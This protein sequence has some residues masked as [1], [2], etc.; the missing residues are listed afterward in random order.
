MM[1]FINKRSILFSWF[2]SYALFL[3]IF[4]I[5]SFL[6][7]FNTSGI[8]ENEI[9]T[10][11]KMLLKD[12]QNELD[13]VLEEGRKLGMEIY[14]NPRIQSILSVKNEITNDDYIDANSSI[15]D[16]KATA[17]LYKSV[18]HFYIVLKNKN[19][20]V[21]YSGLL[22]MK[23][24]YEIYYPEYKDNYNSWLG[25]FDQKLLESYTLPFNSQTLLY[26]RTLSSTD[27]DNLNNSVIV[28]IDIQKL[29]DQLSVI[30][31]INNGTALI[32]DKNNSLIA[33]SRQFEMTEY[34]RTQFTKNKNDLF[35]TNISGEKVV[36]SYINSRVNDWKYVTVIPVNTFLDKLNKIRIITY[37]GIGIC[38]LLGIVLTLYFSRKNYNPISDML[39]VLSKQSGFVRDNSEKNEYG[40]IKTAIKNVIDNNA[41]IST[42][43]YKQNLKLRSSFIEELLKGLNSQDI[44][45]HEAVHLYNLNFIS[46]YFAVMLFCIDENSMDSGSLVEKDID[47]HFIISNVLE[48]MLSLNHKSFFANDDGITACLLNIGE[49]KHYTLKADLEQ[50]LSNAQN[51]INKFFHFTFA[52]SISSVHE[53]I[54]EIPSAYKE[55]LQAM[56]YKKVL[57]IKNNLSYDDISNNSDDTY[58]YPLNKE[59]FLIN[60]I[61]NGNYTRAKDTLDEIFDVN[62]EKNHI[63][64]DLA[65][66]LMLNLVS[67]MIRA[68]KEVTT[69]NQGYF[70]EDLNPIS[71]LLPCK[72]IEEMKHQINIFLNEFCKFTSSLGK[73]NSNW[74]VTDLLPYIKENFHDE[75][76]TV[77]VIAEKFNV[78]PVYMSKIFKDETGEGLLEYINKTRV[79]RAKQLLTDKEDRTLEDISIAVGFSNVRTFGRSFKKYEGVTPGK[80][81]ESI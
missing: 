15:K 55:A 22:T 49:G 11:N 59:Q 76:L 46:D 77:S 50:T 12:T 28:S 63:T 73:S 31:K 10:A 13:K 37:S 72:S 16:L 52:A 81:R 8:I 29:T 32:L 68:V 14:F 61:K 54:E 35:Y 19:M 2:L 6:I 70:L 51:F 5:I 42:Q 20:V 74:V 41:E 45:P 48:E 62:L 1:G 69:Q 36:V 65:Q 57:G 78:H 53:G 25:I 9:N 43:L 17:S 75:N 56:H 3:I 80:Y 66:C 40:I 38:M 67:T 71:R 21:S 39:S 27:K 58:Y 44:P 23:H 18:D 4:L 26:I 64:V 79:E 33:S 47:V 24:F 34:L 7:Y 30:D 60:F